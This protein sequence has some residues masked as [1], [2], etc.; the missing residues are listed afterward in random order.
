MHQLVSQN[1]DSKEG[2]NAL[3]LYATEGILVSDDTGTIT[4]ANPSAEKLFGYGKGELT[5][6]KIE[7]LIPKKLSDKHL[8]SRTKF[9]QHPHPRSM[10][11][12]MELH[13]LKKDGTEFPVEISLSP[14]STPE[15]KFVIAFI[16]DISI[17]KQAEDKLKNYSVELERQVKN[18][19]LIL[20]EAVDELQKTKEDLRQALEKEKDLNELKTR[21]V[22]MASHEF[23]TPLTTMLSSL[24]LVTK[25]G[26][27]KDT[28]NQLKHVGKI[29][30][31][32]NNLTDI[33]NDFLSVSKLEE[34]KI[35]NLPEAINLKTFINEI[36]SDMLGMA[37]NN[38]QIAL[39]YS[40]NEQVVLDKKLV[41]NIL[42][43]LISNAL[44]FSP[45]GG[46]VEVSVKVQNS[47]LRIS[48]KDNG[49]GI[50]KE[51]QEHLFERFFRGNNAT[52][53]Q[54]TGLGLAIVSRYAELMNATLDFESKENKGTTFTIII[55]Q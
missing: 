53:I 13:G 26:E 28:E 1:V 35:E 11:Q 43:N 39:S 22:S 16:I 5:G 48:V 21:F 9:Q 33:L 42:F 20:E 7:T 52:H 55:P 30:T 50:P 15:G 23:R 12:G 41:K 19:T 3:F 6:Q 40:G 36:I 51:D 46:T 45:N 24:S 54:G 37:Q 4:Q 8:E 27:Q 47:S 2:V 14:Y 34:G 18:R 38:Q 17:R 44:K 25:Y 31:S 10:G 29:K 49:I 32:I